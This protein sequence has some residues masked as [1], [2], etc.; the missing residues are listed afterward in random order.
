M[1]T[2]TL[3]SNF[4]S[5]VLDPRM[6]SRTD[7]K[8]Y[9]NGVQLGD[10]VIIM[11]HGG[12]RR[13]PGS[14]FM[15]QIPTADDGA[16]LQTAA[17]SFNSTDQQYLLVFADSKIYFYLDGVLLTNINGSGFDYLVSPWPVAISKQLKW[18]QSADTMIIVH[19]DHAPRK[20][21]RGATDT[22]WTL[23]TLAFDF[24]PKLDYND[25]LSPAPTSEVQDVTFSGFAVGDNFK[26]DLEGVV[27]ENITYDSV[28]A[29]LIKRL[30]RALS[31]L[32]NTGSGDIAVTHTGGTTYRITFQNGAARDYDLMT[33]F[34]T[35]GTGTIGVAAV[36]NGVP[37]TED[38]WSA[39]R[40]YPRTV[41]FYENRLIFGGT[42][43]KVQ[44][45]F[46]SVTN[47]FYN[48]DIGEGLD[49]DAIMKTLDTDQVN[50]I[51]AVF[52]GR[53]LQVYTEGGE[54]F[55]PD[56]PITPE[57]SSFRPQTSHGSAFIDPIKA[58]GADI[59]L[60]RYGRGLYQFLYNDV[61]SAYTSTSL[62]R[63]ASH[64]L[65]DPV[66]MDY[67]RP[68]AEEDCN[69]IYVVND[70]GSMAVLNTL[71]S[72]ELAGWSRWTTDGRYISITVLAE[73]VF[74]VV[75]RENGTGDTVYYVEEFDFD[76]LTDCA[77]KDDGPAA[78]VWATPA[79]LNGVACRV[80]GDNAN[81]LPRTPAAG[82]VTLEFEVE[83][84]E[85]GLFFTP[86]IHMMPPYVEAPGQ[87]IQLGRGRYKYV[88]CN[89]RSSKGIT[90]NGY[91]MPERYMDI[92]PLDT[93]PAALTGVFEVGLA[94]WGEL[95]PLVLTQPDPEPMTILGLETEVE[96]H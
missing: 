32:Y 19:E 22:S 78:T 28:T 35:T 57:N 56:F 72:E 30:D 54:F 7:L 40:G 63:L 81:M 76:Y 13:R 70:D 59:F 29:T 47:S 2:R 12:T 66:D 37:R 92:D 20:L 69:Y 14:R 5:G 11:P 79:H 84:I 33:G 25:G 51:Q 21:V 93:S 52:A 26:L 24:V 68:S 91:P 64:L 31:N 41:T 44:T 3:K 17:F 39:T 4:T 95:Q 96:M 16:T 89:V 49:D 62:S 75:E 53:H 18:A 50:Q 46:M 90:V 87:Q 71:R 42:K 43:S 88:R 48:F 27:T 23:S 77:F 10:N 73:R 36:T 83:E 8:H 61:E 85:I 80:R 1:K 15:H 58:D 65:V 9:F 60:D 86:L 6:L 67:Q 34:A 74:A 55:V 94:G 45:V 38:A 82:S